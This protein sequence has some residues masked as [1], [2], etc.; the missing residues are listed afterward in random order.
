MKPAFFVPVVLLSLLFMA[1]PSPSQERTLVKGDIESGGFGA[2][3]AKLTEVQG[4]VAA[5]A[6]LRG[7]WVIDHVFVLGAGFYGLAS[8]VAISD[9][10]GRDVEFGYGGIELEYIGDWREVLHW[11]IYGL[12]GGGAI[13][14]VDQ[15]DGVFVF[16]PALNLEANV[17]SFFHLELGGGYRVVAGVTGPELSNSGMSGVFGALMLKFGSF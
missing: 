2:A 15:T 3:V 9:A 4:D 14:Y 12:V 10:G 5:I 6:G 13:E 17:T 7:G 16:E 1:S 11:S 8:D